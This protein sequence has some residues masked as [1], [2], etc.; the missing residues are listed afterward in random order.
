MSK[1]GSSLKQKLFNMLMVFLTMG[2]VGVIA[3]GNVMRLEWAWAR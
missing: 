1:V 2:I 3:V